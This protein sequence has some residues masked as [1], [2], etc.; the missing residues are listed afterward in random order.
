M[1]Q[2]QDKFN[3]NTRLSRLFKRNQE[4]ILNLGKIQ[5]SEDPFTVQQDSPSELDELK[6]EKSFN[7]N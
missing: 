2:E 6:S 5:K 3:P 7:G 1:K 4:E